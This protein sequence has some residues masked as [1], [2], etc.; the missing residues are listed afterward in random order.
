MR[1]RPLHNPA[2]HMACPLHIIVLGPPSDRR[3]LLIIV[4]LKHI[5]AMLYPNPVLLVLLLRPLPRHNPHPNPKVNTR[6]YKLTFL[7]PPLRA[8]LEK[9]PRLAVRM[10]PNFF[11]S[12]LT[13]A[14]PTDNPS[15]SATPSTRTIVGAVSL[16]TLPPG[17]F[18]ASNEK[19]QRICRQCGL[20]GRYKD[21]KCVEKWGP[22]PEG[23]GTVCDRCRKKMKRVERRGTLDPH[24]QNTTS[25]VHPRVVHAPVQERDHV[26]AA[27]AAVA[28]PQGSDRSIGRTDTVVVPHPPPPQH[29]QSYSGPPESREREAGSPRSNASS[30][31]VPR[32][33]AEAAHSVPSSRSRSRSPL[34]PAPPPPPQRNGTQAQLP[35]SKLPPHISSG[36]ESDAEADPE[37]EAEDPD[38]D[39][40]EAVDAAEASSGKAAIA[41]WIKREIEPV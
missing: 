25:F 16:P 19:G 37:A 2:M 15:V 32:P 38:A 33:K 28:T 11:F 41:P 7:L 1:R 34:A 36:G 29:L 18:P 4:Y 13:N 22:G 9:S 35:P 40:L 21:G 20:P 39:L 31:T 10:T 30:L 12:R 3:V 14:D 23:P 8:H 6:P 24:S 27:A 26:H 5:V 17:G